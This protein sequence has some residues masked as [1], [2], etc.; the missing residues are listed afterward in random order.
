M[1]EIPIHRVG[2]R[3]LLL[4][5]GDRELVI[6]TAV[7][8][9]TMIMAMAE[10]LSAFAGILLWLGA[11]WALRRMAKADPL[12]RRVYI[13]HQFLYRRYYPARSTP[14]C[15]VNRERRDT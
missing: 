5:G 11:L 13:R 8:S 4:L 6:Y 3:P 14:Y 10:W 1:R 12:L 7:L 2:T 9:T 15:V